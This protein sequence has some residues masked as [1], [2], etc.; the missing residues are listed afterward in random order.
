MQHSLSL[1]T[2]MENGGGGGEDV[3]CRKEAVFKEK[4]HLGQTKLLFYCVIIILV[5]VSTFFVYANI[6]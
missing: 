5:S 6:A 3:L 1:N 2:Y 4:I